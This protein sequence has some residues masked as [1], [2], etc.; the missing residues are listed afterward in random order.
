MLLVI[1]LGVMLSC[2]H[3]RHVTYWYDWT[4]MPCCCLLFSCWQTLT[5]PDAD[6]P[7]TKINA[8]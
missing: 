4:I 6:G 1:V 5:A 7:F 3:I 2:W 8:R